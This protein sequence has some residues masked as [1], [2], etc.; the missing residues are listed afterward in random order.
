[1]RWT[2]CPPSATAAMARIAAQVAAAQ[3][4][5]D[6][7]LWQ[8]LQRL[9]D[10]YPNDARIWTDLGRSRFGAGDMEGASRAAARAAALAPAIPMPD[11]ARRSAPRALWSVG[12]LP[13]SRRRW[14]GMPSPARADPIC[15]DVGRSGQGER[16]IGGDPFGL[17]VAAGQP[18]SLL[19]SGGDSRLGRGLWSG[20]AT[21]P[22]D[23]RR[24]ADAARHGDA[25]RRDRLCARDGRS[26]R[27]GLGPGW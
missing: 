18:G 20:A 5:G 15:R 4:D 27:C 13:G 19:P 9:A 14:R 26:V 6:A 2:G 10:R 3:E 22:A 8:E 16:G 23:R 11:P 12:G 25:R 24:A 21:A 7:P 1:M 17:G